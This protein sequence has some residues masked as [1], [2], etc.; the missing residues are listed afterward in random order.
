MDTTQISCRLRKVKSFLG[1][2][3]SD[4]LPHPL[5]Q[6]CTVIIN[7]DPHTKIGSHWVAIHFRPN[8]S[9]SYYFDSYGTVPLVTDIHT[10][11]RRNCTVADYNKRQ[12]QGMTSN[13]CGKYCCLFSL[14]MDLGYTPQQ[15]VVLFDARDAD[16]TALRVRVST[17]ASSYATRQGSMQL[18]FSIK[19][20]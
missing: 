1:V 7:A 15:F 14:Y 19:G 8:S 6:S 20:R 4:L 16:R 5:R 10:F 11:I 17:A 13:V 3:H 2:F 18:Q 9:S 12:V